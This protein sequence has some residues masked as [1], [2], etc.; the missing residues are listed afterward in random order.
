MAKKCRLVYLR[1]YVINM[2]VI[3]EISLALKRIQKQIQKDSKL[4]TRR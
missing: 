2:G 3:M 4:T 1:K